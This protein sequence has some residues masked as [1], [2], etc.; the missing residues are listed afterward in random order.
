MTPLFNDGPL[1][2][3]QDYPK[4][5]DVSHLRYS[6][7]LRNRWFG[8]RKDAACLEFASIGESTFLHLSY[9]VGADWLIENDL[10]IYVAPKLNNTA[11]ETDYLTM[12][13]SALSNA[14][15]A[16]EGEDLFE[17]DATKPFI[18]LESKNDL[19]TPLL[20]LQFL[21]LVKRIVQRGLKRSFYP[22]TRKLTSRVRGKIRVA[23]T[24]KQAGMK[25]KVLDNVCTYTEFDYDCLENRILK[26]ALVF[27]NRY[28]CNCQLPK[29]VQKTFQ[30]LL[31]FIN[32][33]FEK[34]S[35]DVSVETMKGLKSNPFF[36][37]Y[38]KAIESAKALMARYGYNIK[39]VKATTVASVPPF[40]INMAKLFELYVLDKLRSAYGSS[41]V[42]YQPKAGSEFPDFL[43]LGHNVVIDAKY[44][45]AYSTSKQRDDIRQLSGYARN[46][47][48]LKIF[49]ASTEPE[50]CP[51]LPCWIIFPAALS[52]DEEKVSSLPMVGSWLPV[53]GYVNFFKTAISLP[54]M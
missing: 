28:L 2:E 35:L 1:F 48:V 14:E 10:A 3:H 46:E 37:E 22:V 43:L 47:E 29:P 36:K 33:A 53:G 52:T 13:F 49:G 9:F 23:D 38:T 18:I 31:S 41:K 8:S 17:I 4:G 44:K 40:W 5:V 34:V 54:T 50:H 39:S 19:I 45:P 42:L 12:L 26:K 24:L 30:G 20:V 6:A 21:S 16:I 15:A 51:V 32:P 11:Q 7:P 27:V 25:G